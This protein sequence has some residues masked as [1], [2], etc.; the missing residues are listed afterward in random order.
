MIGRRTARPVAAFIDPKAKS[1]GRRPHR[2][3]EGT[4]L[5]KRAAYDTT[6][7]MY[8]PPT[9]DGF[10]ESYVL[11]H[12][13]AEHLLKTVLG[14]S[15][16]EIIDLMDRLYNFRAVTFNTRTRDIIARRDTWSKPL[17]EDALDMPPKDVTERLDRTLTGLVGHVRS[18]VRERETAG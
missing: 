17:N 4:Y 11:E 16:Q 1:P 7:E 8:E 15:E 5:F 6:V 14:L 18:L 12:F 3:V 9:P 2:K 13:D 10:V